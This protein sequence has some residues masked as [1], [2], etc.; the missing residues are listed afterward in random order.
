[1]PDPPKENLRFK[2]SANNSTYEKK[3][4]LTQIKSK[5]IEKILKTCYHSGKMHTTQPGEHIH[6]SRHQSRSLMTQI[7]LVSDH[8]PAKND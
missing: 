2:W 1:M 4:F 8:N 7:M 5:E 6:D 3:L